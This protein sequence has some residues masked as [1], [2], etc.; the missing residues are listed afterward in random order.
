MPYKNNYQ[1]ALTYELSLDKHFYYRSVYSS[2]DFLSELGG[3]FSAFGRFCLLII[4]AF[5]YFGSFQFVMADNFFYRNGKSYKNDVQWNSVNSLLLNI[6]TFLPK[7]LLCCCM[8][9][10]KE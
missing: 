4:T 5:N 1:N 10:S 9:P 2:L 7:R 3:L 6:H 8:R